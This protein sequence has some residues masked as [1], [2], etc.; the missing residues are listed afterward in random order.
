MQKIQILTILRAPSI[1]H[2][3]SMPR[4]RENMQFEKVKKEIIN[5]KK[6]D[7]MQNHTFYAKKRYI[8]QKV[9]TRGLNF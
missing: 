8:L 1:R 3:G 4:A 2:S 7:F 5:S 6:R 9:R